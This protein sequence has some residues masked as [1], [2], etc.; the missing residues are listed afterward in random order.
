MSVSRLL[1]S[2]IKKNQLFHRMYIYDERKTQNS[3]GERLLK[4]NTVGKSLLERLDKVEKRIWKI[5]NFHKLNFRFEAF[6]LNRSSRIDSE[7]CLY[8]SRSTSNFF[9]I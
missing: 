9:F 3:N 7:F 6:I 4:F 2:P 1:H 8:T 5:L